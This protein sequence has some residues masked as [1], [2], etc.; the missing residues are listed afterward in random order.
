VCTGRSFPLWV[1]SSEAT[2]LQLAE[3]VVSKLRR[4]EEV[5]EEALEQ[6]ES[7]LSSLNMRLD[8][9]SRCPSLA[10]TR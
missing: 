1:G 7:Y 5:G 9:V 6:L 3:S 4:K 8:L 2:S 10:Q